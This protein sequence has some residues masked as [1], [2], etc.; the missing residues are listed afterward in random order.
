MN[1]RIDMRIKRIEKGLH[2][3]NSRGN[4]EAI[5]LAT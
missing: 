2:A 4:L 1:V 5:I 3:L